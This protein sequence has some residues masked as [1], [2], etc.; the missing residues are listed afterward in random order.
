MQ[1]ENLR[2]EVSHGTK[3]DEQ[4]PISDDIGF[5]MIG[6]DVY[7]DESNNKHI[8]TL[9][10]NI[11]SSYNQIKKYESRNSFES[12]NFNLR[13]DRSRDRSRDYEVWVYPDE[14]FPIFNPEAMLNNANLEFG[15]KDMAGMNIFEQADS[16]G[17]SLDSYADDATGRKDE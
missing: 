6:D 16:V 8:N 9:F 17:N 1:I 13:R 4:V 5:K 7:T 12:A 2:E 10:S 3:D 11:G 14:L 15:Y